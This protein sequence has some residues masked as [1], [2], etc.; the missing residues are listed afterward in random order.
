[1]ADTPRRC[2]PHQPWVLGYPFHK[3]IHHELVVQQQGQMFRRSILRSVFPRKRPTRRQRLRRH[4]KCVVPSSQLAILPKSE[5]ERRG[6]LRRIQ[7]LLHLGILQFLLRRHW[8]C[9]IFRHR[10]HRCDSQFA[11][12]AATDQRRPQRHPHCFVNRS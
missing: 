7:H 10:Q 11:R 8:Q 1:M 5:L 12:P 6:L 3:P 9:Q 2:D 4:Y